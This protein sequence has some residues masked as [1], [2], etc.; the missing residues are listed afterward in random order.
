MI[1]EWWQIKWAADIG[2]WL[3]LP[4]ILL[5]LKFSLGKIGSQLLFWV[6]LSFWVWFLYYLF[7]KLIN[8]LNTRT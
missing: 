7:T 5:T 8:R 6:S 1:I 2:V 4:P 3:A